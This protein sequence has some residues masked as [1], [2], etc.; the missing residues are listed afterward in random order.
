MPA[1]LHG[2]FLLH[3]LRRASAALGL[4]R[5]AAALAPAGVPNLLALLVAV[6]IYIRCST[7]I[8]ILRRAAALAPAGVLNL[9]ALLALLV[10]KALR[11]ML[12]AR[13]E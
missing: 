8:Q 9:L 10:Q 4:L 5:R 7:K 6:Y 3:F 11:A 12:K 1:L 13:L 2:M